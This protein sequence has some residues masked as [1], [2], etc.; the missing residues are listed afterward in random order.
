MEASGELHVPGGFTPGE[1]ALSTH[2]MGDEMGPRAGLDAVKKRR[3]SFH[4]RE[5]NPDTPAVQTTSGR[6]TD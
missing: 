4:Y 1:R 3:I 6:Y 2:W 5:L